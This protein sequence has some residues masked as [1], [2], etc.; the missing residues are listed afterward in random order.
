MKQ[1]VQVC[2]LLVSLF[3]SS[4][5]AQA[6]AGDIVT[7]LGLTEAERPVSESEGWAQARHIVVFGGLF[8][9]A[10]IKGVAPDA[11]VT[12]L[13]FG[14]FANPAL[15][16]ADVVFGWCSDALIAATPRLRWLQHYAAGVENCVKIE[17]LAE[18]K[19]LLTNMQKAS[20]PAIAEHAI[21]MMFALARRFPEYLAYQQSG[22]WR[23][24]EQDR[25]NH[26][27][28]A[29]KTMLVYGLGGI[30]TEIARRAAALGMQ[31]IAIR[32]SSRTGPEFV[33]QVGLP[34]DLLA[35]AGR[36]DVIAN[37]APLTPATRGALGDAFFAVLKPTALFINVGRGATVD[38]D[39][40]VAALKSGKLAGAGL[41]V[42]DPEPLPSGHALW[43]MPNVLITPHVAG[44]SDNDYRRYRAIIVENLN[45]YQAG[46][47]MLNVVDL[48]RG[49]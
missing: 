17:A 36:A 21:A 46:G 32:N 9:A 11:E 33:A 31:V 45:R 2:V 34:E 48:E 8:D 19:I 1:F 40:L 6:V 39:A 12:M 29:G 25:S 30:G 38:T 14:D 35:F 15:Q 5:Q 26:Y 41:D 23:R 47:K 49:Y 43:T 3:A 7:A 13:E 10:A 42:T 27:E 18:R 24:G 22:E 28:L 20:S 16:T 44:V 37:A 4:L